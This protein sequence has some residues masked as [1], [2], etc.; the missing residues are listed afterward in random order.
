MSNI[1]NMHILENSRHFKLMWVSFVSKFLVSL[2]SK[3]CE[4]VLFLSFQFRYPVTSHHILHSPVLVSVFCFQVPVDLGFVI[5]FC[6]CLLFSS[7]Q[8]RYPVASSQH[9]SSILH[10][11]WVSFV[12]A[13][14]F[15]FRHPVASRQSPFSSLKAGQLARILPYTE[16]WI[17]YVTERKLACFRGETPVWYGGEMAPF[18]PV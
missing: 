14:R 11:W 15:G 10:F 12:F 4:C 7:F 18:L 13:S 8:F 3:F 5:Q 16:D 2:S 9:H 6:E 17:Q 1:M